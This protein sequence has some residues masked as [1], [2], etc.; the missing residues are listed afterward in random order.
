M[1]SAVR[2][3]R[4]RGR[5]IA[6][7]ASQV[8]TLFA[9][10]KHTGTPDRATKVTMSVAQQEALT[11]HWTQLIANPWQAVRR[12]EINQVTTAA[13][14]ANPNKRAGMRLSPVL[15]WV[16][17]VAQAEHINRLEFQA[18]VATVRHLLRL[19]GAQ[20]RT[21]YAFA[22]DNTTALS[23]ITRRGS[24]DASIEAETE[25]LYAELEEAES[26][27]FVS[28]I[29]TG[30]MPADA[31]TRNNP[32]DPAKVSATDA[33]LRD[34]AKLYLTVLPLGGTLK[35]HRIE[36]EQQAGT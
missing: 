34:R 36:S 17:P 19:P 18:A 13:S 33:L 2:L 8:G 25:T 15:S 7:L 9:R 28:W 14:D 16:W 6:E 11:R 23:W 12:I 27:L 3:G 35:Q 21:L 22:V 26:D 30:A 5:D 29:P 20:R 32:A 1:D 10:N 24:P 4:S 31:L